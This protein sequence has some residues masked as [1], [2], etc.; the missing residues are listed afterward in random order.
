MEAETTNT[1]QSESS[2]RSSVEVKPLSVSES[3]VIEE[4]D[5]VFLEAIS[6]CGKCGENLCNK[7]SKFLSCLHTFCSLCVKQ[8]EVVDG[9]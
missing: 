3:I 1:A 9:E 7:A 8:L 5:K 2:D 4:D 6:V